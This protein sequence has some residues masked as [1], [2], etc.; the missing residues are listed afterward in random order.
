MLFSSIFLFSNCA[1]IVQTREEYAVVGEE[2]NVNGAR[3]SAELLT[4]QEKV[5]HSLSAMVY[6]AAGEAATGP[7]KC[8]LTAWGDRQSHRAMTIERHPFKPKAAK[9]AYLLAN[10]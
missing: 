10:G 8:L 5:N 9:K 7:Y 3:L 1:H 6:F 4:T 2:P